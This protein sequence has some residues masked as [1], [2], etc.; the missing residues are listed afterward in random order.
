MMARVL[1][2][3]KGKDKAGYRLIVVALQQSR[4][5]DFAISNCQNLCALRG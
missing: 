4:K 3:A 2:V 1:E 5:F